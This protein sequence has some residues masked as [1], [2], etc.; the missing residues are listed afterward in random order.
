VGPG[1]RIG[2]RTELVAHVNVMGNTVIGAENR[3][4]PQAVIGTI[5]QDLKY[6]GGNTACRIGDRNTIREGVTVN[7]GTE[8]GGGDTVIGDDNLLMAYCHVAHDCLL[9]N[10]VIMANGVLLGGHIRVDD[11]AVIGGNAA[12]QH[13][14]SV[15]TMAFV[16]GMS[17]VVH[18]APPYLI[19][20]G[21]PARPRGVN[22][23][24]LERMG[25]SAPAV[26]LLWEVYRDLYRSGAFHSALSRWE[27][28]E[29]AP[30]EVRELARFLRA[31]LDG[32]RG[33]GREALRPDMRA[34]APHGSA[35]TTP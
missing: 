23:V 17:R 26:A 27:L 15:G 29:G 20:E 2:E 31:T 22:Q 13:Y 5:P 28:E 24:K 7:A 4:F 3:I 34:A 21:N 19:T 1:V 25:V 16:G 35:P 11:H 12:L 10:G 18:D 30:P 14:A 32:R 6:R 33:R 9:G 8:E